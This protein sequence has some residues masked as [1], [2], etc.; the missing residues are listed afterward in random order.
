MNINAAISELRKL[1]LAVSK[2][3]R[4]PTLDEIIFAENELEFTFCSDYKKFL[5]EASDVVFGYIEPCT[6]V[7]ENSHTNLIRVVKEAWDFMNVPKNLLPICEDNGNYYCL[8]EKNE[9][10]YWSHDGFSNEKWN[11]LGSW[12]KEVWINDNQKINCEK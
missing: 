8:N 12:I 7:S 10:Q 4:L 5:L 3:S 11:N 1:N 9:V 2:P 6:I